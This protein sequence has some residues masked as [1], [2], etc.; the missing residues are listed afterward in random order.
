MEFVRAAK[1]GARLAFTVPGRAD[2]APDVLQLERTVPRRFGRLFFRLS[3]PTRDA[4]DGR[5]S[6]RAQRPGT[7]LG[8]L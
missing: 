3:A 4:S 6:A 2:G 5:G 8:G 1:P 7:D